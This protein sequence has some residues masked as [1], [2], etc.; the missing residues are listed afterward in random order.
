MSIQTQ[1][2]SSMT[3]TPRRVAVFQCGDVDIVQSVVTAGLDV[4]YFYDPSFGME[5]LDFDDIPAFD[6]VA[7]SLP[8]GNVER[9]QAW[10]LVLIFMRGRSPTSFLLVGKGIEQELVDIVRSQTKPL[11]YAL[12]EHAV[13]GLVYVVGSIAGAAFGWQGVVP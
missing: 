6:V 8:N 12:D 9:K 4:V 3:A 11:G 10:E 13:Q 7:A 2:G 5:Y 1:D